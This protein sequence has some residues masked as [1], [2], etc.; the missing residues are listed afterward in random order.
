MVLIVSIVP[1]RDLLF[2]LSPREASRE[3]NGLNPFP[4][5]IQIAEYLRAH[6]RADARVAVLG[7]E[8]EIYFYAHRHS[9]TGYIYTYSM[10]EPQPFAQTMQEEM[11]HE[12]ENARPEYVV[13]VD[14]RTSWAARPDSPTSINDWWT[15]YGAQNYRLAGIAD[16]LSAEHTEFHWEGAENVASYRPQSR[17]FLAVFKRK[18]P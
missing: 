6:T 8:P 14:V 12:L 17:Q 16:I 15:S 11:I 10:M 3:L 13:F 18:V 4:D 2:R 9:A 5:A 1:Q 7:S